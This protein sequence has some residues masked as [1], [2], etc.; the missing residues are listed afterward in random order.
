MI[1]HTI[2]RSNGL[3][4]C[5]V[6]RSFRVFGLCI[7]CKPFSE[8]LFVLQPHN[9]LL[10]LCAASF[11]FQVG[12]RSLKN[13]RC[14][15]DIQDSRHLPRTTAPRN[16]Q[17]LMSFS[18]TPSKQPSTHMNARCHFSSVLNKEALLKH[19]DVTERSFSLVFY[20]VLLSLSLYQWAPLGNYT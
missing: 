3:K 1:C 20:H 12:V 10:F 17:L 16:L 4:S 11:F 8:R 9:R 14:Q 19:G 5:N 15:P 2:F 6:W 7:C 13:I 18:V